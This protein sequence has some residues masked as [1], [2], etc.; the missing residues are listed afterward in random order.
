VT[1]AGALIRM[2][3]HAFSQH[4]ALADVASDMVARQ[5]RF[6]KDAD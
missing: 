1:Q 2:R 4:R 5:L 3:A 6:D